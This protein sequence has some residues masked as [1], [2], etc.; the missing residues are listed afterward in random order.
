MENNAYIGSNTF[1]YWNKMKSLVV[2]VFFDFLIFSDISPKKE[3]RME[4]RGRKENERRKCWEKPII[5][6]IYYGN[7]ED[8]ED[9]DGGFSIMYVV[10]SRFYLPNECV[11]LRISACHVLF[12]F[13]FPLL[14]L[15]TCHTIPTCTLIHVYL[16][17]FRSQTV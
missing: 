13:F 7:E 11:L 4:R 12:S 17:I 5:F 15:H 6:V 10:G 1:I 8:E 9:E 14:L 16:P 2:S 3:K